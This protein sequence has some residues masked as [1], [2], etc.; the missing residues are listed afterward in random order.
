M[1][2]QEFLKEKKMR[3]KFAILL[4]LTFLIS[5]SGCERKI[6]S[7]T[8]P[9]EDFFI[10]STPKEIVLKVGDQRIDLCWQIDDTSKIGGYKIYRSDSSG[11]T[12]SLYDSTSVAQ[13]TD[14]SVKNNQEY[15][16]QIS[17]LDKKGFE[18]YKSKIVSAR[19]NLYS[20]IIN[21]NR[22]LTNSLNVSLR[23]IA[24]DFTSYMLLG[25][26]SV[27]SNSSWE[28]FSTARNWVLESG[29]GEKAVYVKYKDQDGN[30]SV[31]FYQD[32]IILDTQA[33]ILSLTE[34]TQGEPK[35]PGEII[36]FR[37]ESGETSGE[38]KVDLGSST[39]IKLYD[40]GTNGDQ[41]SADGVYELDYL[42]P[43]NSEMEDALV[44]GH[45]KDKAGNQAPE[46]IAPGKVTIQSP[47]SAVLLFPPSASTQST[48]TLYWT[49][50]Q[51]NDFYSYR[52][53]RGKTNLV[54]SDSLLVTTVLSNTTTSFTDTGLSSGTTY[55]YKVYVYDQSGLCSGSN[56]ENGTTL[57]NMPPAKVTVSLSAVDSTTLKVSWSQNHDH[58][59][60]FYQIFR[61]DTTLG[62]LDTFSVSIVSQQSTTTYDDS[63]LKAGIKYCYYIT[64]H[65]KEGLVSDPS[66]L[67][68]WPF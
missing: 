50:N 16:Y 47:P 46:F 41:I 8:S 52:V 11:V 62:V 14:R 36:H 54:N 33:R 55:Y 21:E 3:G 45:F 56:V 18:G 23:L 68:C 28:D 20:I 7:P 30:E 34:D 24:P 5:I 15:F 43:L 1:F 13:Y 49:R 17:A 57:E 35:S 25:N 4:L 10:P 63:Q 59:F 48:L 2:N 19:P 31:S 39:N 53:Y 37:L 26:D 40:D 6:K 32:K 12:P 66:D 67:V 38:A 65:D 22:E 51:D 44:T 58:D 60:D 27:F 64:V 9:E 42:I 61:V 29:D